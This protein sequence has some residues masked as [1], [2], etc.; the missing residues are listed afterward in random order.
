MDWPAGGR[1]VA[2]LPA[3]LPVSQP[4]AA[5]AALGGP[6]RSISAVP[7]CECL[8]A[9]DADPRGVREAQSSSPSPTPRTTAVVVAII[10]RAERRT[11]R[12]ANRYYLLLLLPY[13]IRP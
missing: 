2:M 4:A 8:A 6:I 10:A 3:G 11:K 7:L 1:V 12:T 13:K 9:P 5:A